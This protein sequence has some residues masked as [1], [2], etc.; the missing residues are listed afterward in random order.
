MIKELIK[1][2]G[3][4]Q[5]AKSEDNDLIRDETGRRVIECIKPLLKEQIPIEGKDNLELDLGLDSLARIELVVALEK[6]FSTKLPESFA[7]EIQTVEEIVRR[8]KEYETG[9]EKEVEKIARWK[10]IIGEEPGLKD[11]RKIGLYHNFLER[12]A[13]IF[14]LPTL[15]VI[16]KFFFKLKVKGLQ[17]LPDKGPYIITPNHASYIDGF[18]IV[19]ALPSRLFWNLYSIGWQAY[20]T[21]PLGLFA[22]LAHVIPIDRETYLQ[23]ALQMATYVLR[24]G[25]SLQVFPEGGR[26][27]DGELME[28]KKG[29]GILALELNLPVVPAYI[30]GSFDVLPRGKKWPKFH[31]VRITFGRPMYPSELNLSKK[32][33]DIDDYQF[34]VNELR[35]RVK[36]LKH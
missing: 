18:A 6:A 30:E 17:N 36:M 3:K 8:I 15:K 12:L 26:S 21:G 20:F 4:E 28:F 14:G 7:S 2:E 29:V 32:T 19:A 1:A 22:R 23:K 25:K 10:D 24:K 16:F 13:I 35:E 31:E 34:F 5:R 33:D 27:Y 11:R 9:K